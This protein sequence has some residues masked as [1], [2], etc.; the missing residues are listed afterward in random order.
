MI[1]T[2]AISLIIP[3]LG[4]VF[5][6]TGAL[7]AYPI[8]FLLPALAFSKIVL[9]DGSGAAPQRYGDDNESSFH[10]VLLSRSMDED[11]D[12]GTPTAKKLGRLVTWRFIFPF[13]MIFGSIASSAIS[14]YVIITTT[15]W[16]TVFTPKTR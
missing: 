4:K 2:T 5:E 10:E 3:D 15:D 9:Y 14:L 6:L 8:D 1:V 7:A 16:S 13:L 11:A 12:R